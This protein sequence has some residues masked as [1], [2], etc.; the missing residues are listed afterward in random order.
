M[1]AVATEVRIPDGIGKTMT[2]L[3]D[4][5]VFV[6][7]AHDDSPMHPLDD[8]DGMGHI[9]SLSRKHESYNYA[10]V[11]EALNSN[12]DVVPLSYFEHGNC[13]WDVRG[14][15]M[16]NW[17]D[18]NWDGVDFAG[19]WIPDK[20]LYGNEPEG[21]QFQLKE[22]D[23]YQCT[24]CDTKF[25]EAKVQCPGCKKDFQIPGNGSGFEIIKIKVSTPERRAWMEEQAASACRV[26]TQY[27]NGEVYAY[28]VAI[29]NV[30]RDSRGEVYDRLSDYRRDK[31]VAEDSCSG[32]FGDDVF[33]EVKSVV[34]SL[35]ER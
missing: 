6:T 5:I 13:I 1:T 15:S 21:E 16:S 31:P 29:Y 9:Y 23:G 28:S 34:Q 26:F 27:C 32:L 10:G 18:F 7:I 8:C 20:A 24:D 33:D 3:G 19:V 17:P 14:S 30:R 2:L 35:I 12:P 25:L 4:R 22:V 11:H